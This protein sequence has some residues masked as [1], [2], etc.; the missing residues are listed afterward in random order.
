MSAGWWRPG[1]CGRPFFALA[2]AL[3]Y[4]CAATRRRRRSLTERWP[5][6]RRRTPAKGVRVKS[7][8]RVR[9]PLSPPD[10]SLVLAS[11][12]SAST[13]YGN[14]RS[15]DNFRGKHDATIAST[16]NGRRWPWAPIRTFRSRRR[17]RV[18]RQPHAYSPQTWTRPCRDELCD[19]ARRVRRDSR[20]TKRG[21]P[22]TGQPVR[23]FESRP[24]RRNRNATARF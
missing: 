4:D 19:S 10:Q 5:S 22:A 17:E 23:E 14:L 21:T 16:G 15:A 20:C 7:P 13:S 12:T 9:I 2:P 6:G 3:Q 11:D 24:L 18:T 8:S 1:S